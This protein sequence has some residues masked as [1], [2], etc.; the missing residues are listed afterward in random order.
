M[1]AAAGMGLIGRVLIG[2]LIL[3]VCAVAWYL[4]TQRNRSGSGCSGNCAGCS[5]Q[6]EKRKE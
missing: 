4:L 5:A 2:A 1:A 3:A 6:C